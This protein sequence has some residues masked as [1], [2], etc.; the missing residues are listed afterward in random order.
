MENSPKVSDIMNEIMGCADACP[1]NINWDED[2]LR[3][4]VL[5]L[6]TFRGIKDM[7]NSPKVSDIM[8]EIWI[9]GSGWSHDGWSVEGVYS[10]ES[11]ALEYVE[12]WVKDRNEETQIRLD[13]IPEDDKYQ[14]SHCMFFEKDSNIDF[15]WSTGYEF[16]FITKH[17]VK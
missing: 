1:Y 14:R 15:N 8:K 9:V 7:E 11:G 4:I 5:E 3:T 6:M 2:T 12:N 17:G 10:T 13:D 16:I